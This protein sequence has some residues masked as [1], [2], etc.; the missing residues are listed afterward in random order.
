MMTL[1]TQSNTAPKSGVENA[2]KGYSLEELRYRRALAAIKCEIG[3]EKV[4]SS[5]AELKMGV[6]NNGLRSFFFG[7]DLLGSLKL[8]DY[9][10][11]GFK[12]SKLVSK[13]W[14]KSK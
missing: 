6:R 12:L 8:V 13:V 2:W 10:I 1:Q 14:K 11:I 5:V 9:L 3:N 7:K 4:R